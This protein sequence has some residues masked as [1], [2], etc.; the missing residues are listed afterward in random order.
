M[1][2]GRDMATTYGIIPWTPD[3]YPL[4][5]DRVR[6]IGDGVAAVAAVDEDTAHPRARSDRRRLRGASRLPRS[7]RGARSRRVDPL[8]PRCQEG[9][10]ER[11]RHQEGEARV[12]RGRSRH[13]SR[14][15]GRRGRVLLRGHDAR[16]PS[17]P[18]VRSGCS[19]R[20]GKLTVW[21]ATQVPHYLHR[22]LLQGA[23]DRSGEGPRHPAA[24]GR[25]VRRQE[26][27]VRPGV[28]RG[29][30]GHEDR[31]SREDPLHPGGGLLRPPGSPPVPHEVP[32]RAPPRTGSSPR[33]T[34]RSCSTAVRTPPSGWSRRTTRGSSCARPT[35][36]RRTDSTRRASTRTSPRAAPSADTARCSPASPSRCRSTSWPRRGRTRPDRDPETQLHRVE[37]AYGQR[38]AHHL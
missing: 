5:V 33:W 13:G 38:V 7:V 25:R 21:S 29:Q 34:P 32:D 18:T 37:H 15:R 10:V 23:R 30:A 1:V 3:E 36:C 26:R 31:P 35:T 20:N 19:R 27:A 9:G 16:R 2:T 8:H 6:Y 14:R 28:L 12:R 24:R 17:S 11:E 22:E 4:C